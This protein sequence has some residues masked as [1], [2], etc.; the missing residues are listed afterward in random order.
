M[1]ELCLPFRF[2]CR[3]FEMVVMVGEAFLMQ[4][5]AKDGIADW[6]SFQTQIGAGLV[7]GDWVEGSEHA[8]VGQNR[9]NPY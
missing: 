3:V 4:M 5:V 9:A 6:F 7:E 8:D 2:G 1:N